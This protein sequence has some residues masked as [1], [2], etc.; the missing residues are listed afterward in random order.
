MLSEAIAL[1]KE[2]SAVASNYLSSGVQVARDLAAFAKSHTSLPLNAKRSILSQTAR[3]TLESNDGLLAAWY[4]FEPDILDGN[5]ASFQ[6]APG[7]TLSGRFVPY[8]Y[9]GSGDELEYEYATLDEEGT[10]EEFYTTPFATRWEY[11]TAPYEFGTEDGTVYR[12]I[13]FCVPVIV[14]GEVIGVAGVDYALSSLEAFAEAFGTFDRYA[15]IIAGDGTLATHPDPN[16]L[17]VNYAD[18]FAFI[19]AD[20]ELL[21]LL[22]MGRPTDFVENS[23]LSGAEVL[24][25]LGPFQS[26]VN[27][28]PW[29]FGISQEL[30]GLYAP[31]RTSTLLL[32]LIGVFTTLTAVVILAW[33]GSRVLKPVSVLKTAMAEVSQGDGD[34]TR[35]LNVASRD[36]LGA[37]ASSFNEF[38]GKLAEIVRV[39]QRSAVRL[40][41][42]GSILAAKVG[43][44]QEAAHRISRAVGQVRELMAEQATGVSET[45]ATVGTI[46]EGVGRLAASIETQSTG[47]TQSS[48]SVEQILSSIASVGN[49][50]ER[51]AN[52][53]SELMS[54]SEEGRSRLALASSSADEASAQSKAQADINEVVAAVAVRTNLLAM[55]AAIEAAHAGDAGKGFAVVAGEIRALAERSG[56]QAKATSKELKAIT[57]SIQRVAEASAEASRSFDAVLSRLDG[58][59]KLAEEIRSA[60]AEQNAGSTQVLEALAEINKETAAVR[61]A[62]AEMGAASKAVLE[63][64]RRLEE[65]SQRASA[66][67]G[68][69]DE[70]AAAIA[71]AAADASTAAIRTEES[72]ALLSEAAGRFKT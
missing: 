28:L 5:D 59:N 18:H 9:R 19:M 6:G 21:D 47:I 16:L 62:S 53:L 58:V 15:F 54:A 8:W 52:S 35:R 44:N 56:E 57:Q 14:D 51:M 61:A 13:S 66:L 69:A 68:G 33:V 29:Y 7:H 67:A 30:E 2:R 36:E 42:D 26:S 22:R 23:P 41:D 50:V 25:V 37:M 4:I 65:S 11:L 60:M 27:N 72:I 10:V 64:T 45:A 34:L 32:S 40:H 31:V 55:N 49:S 70:E 1:A 12:A 20:G 46:A 71:D 17:G 63:E 48:A 24:T 38:S 39:V 43:E 3:S